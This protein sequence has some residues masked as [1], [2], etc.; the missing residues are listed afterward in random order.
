MKKIYPIFLSL[1]LVYF[2][3]YYTNRVVDIIKSKDPIMLQ[4]KSNKDKYEVD[5][6]DAI[7]EE[8]Y[9]IPGKNGLKVNENK[10]FQKMK[11]YGKYN[12]SLLVFDEI[13]PDV[14]LNS[15][16]DKYIESGRNDLKQVALVFK[17]ERFDTID[18]VVDILSSNETKATFFLDGLFVDNNYETIK[19]LKNKYELELLSYNNGYEKAYFKSGLQSLYNITNIKPKYCYAEYDNKKVL[20]LCDNL[21]LHTIIPTINSNNSFKLIKEKLNSGAIISLDIDDNNLSTIINYIKQRGYK[22]VTLDELLLE[23]YEK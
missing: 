16:Y 14:S 18:N 21:G 15:Y 3:F 1:L 9:I 22:F 23:S 8:N 17:V 4:I 20:T 11:K 10:S 19:S 2:S 12:E 6:T 5:F 7:I 13:E